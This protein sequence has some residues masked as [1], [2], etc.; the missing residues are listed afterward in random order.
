M[1][2]NKY[3]LKLVGFLAG[4]V[5]G[6][7]GAGGGL[8]LVPFLSNVIKDDE[9]VSRATSVYTIFFMVIA[10]SIFHIKELE[11]D[12]L[13]TIKCIIGGLIGSF[14]GSKLLLK[15]KNK[16]LDLLFIIFLIYSGIKMVM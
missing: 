9:C 5:C 16:I 13:L 15:L 1:E 14:L 8:I 12:Y 11:I 7:L 10:A 2:K 6:F 3:L 4:I